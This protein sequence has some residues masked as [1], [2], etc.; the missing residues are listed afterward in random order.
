MLIK[1][2]KKTQTAL[3]NIVS[4]IERG[5]I[6]ETTNK[7]LHE[8]ETKLRECEEMIAIEKSREKIKLTEYEIRRYY[9]LALKQEIA[10]AINF[11]VKEIIVF[12]DKIEIILNSPLNG[13][14]ENR[15]HCFYEQFRYISVTA[16]A[17][18][19][20]DKR[21]ILVKMSV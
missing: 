16:F 19:Q 2:R 7:R 20:T 17:Q 4:A 15:D 9:A 11:L 10:L 3:D 12:K 6:S 5:I 13:P 14:D 21:A 8:L 1:E 18:Y